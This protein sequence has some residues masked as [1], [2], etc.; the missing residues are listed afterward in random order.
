MV[1]DLT[2]TESGRR[3]ATSPQPPGRRPHPVAV[4]GSPEP[5]RQPSS[6]VWRTVTLRR[7]GSSPTTGS[8]VP[9]TN[10]GTPWYA[11]RAGPPKTTT[12]PDSSGRSTHGRP[13]PAVEPNRNTPVDPDAEGH[14]RGGHD[15]V[16][17]GMHPHL[18]PGP[19]PVDQRDVRLEGGGVLGH[20][21]IEARPRPRPPVGPDPRATAG[22]RAPDHR[23]RRPA[24][25]E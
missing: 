10:L 23:R 21:G 6:P 8:S 4:G 20:R 16:G 22:T 7:P 18:R 24:V 19:V 13:R 15:L 2:A 3:A 17:V 11:S 25:R 14:D 12:S 5:R 1:A 9:D